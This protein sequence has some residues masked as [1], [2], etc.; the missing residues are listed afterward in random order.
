MFFCWR[1]QSDAIVG[2]MFGTYTS[3]SATVALSL[4]GRVFENSPKIESFVRYA[5]AYILSAWSE[6]MV[7]VPSCRSISKSAPCVSF[8]NDRRWM[9][10][11]VPPIDGFEND[12]E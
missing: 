6:R 3:F 2:C 12:D 10:P 11:A 4:S 1:R 7:S 5:I 8:L 9:Y